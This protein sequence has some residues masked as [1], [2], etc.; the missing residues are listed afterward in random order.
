[1]SEIKVNSDTYRASLINK[2]FDIDNQVR[3]KKIGR[4]VVDYN[5]S[6]TNI[7]KIQFLLSDNDG[8][9]VVHTIFIKGK[10]RQEVESIFF[11]SINVDANFETTKIYLVINEL[12]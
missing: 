3:N 7:S 4:L 10:G 9:R 1:M 6:H 8:S 5:L 11:T 2:P 12:N